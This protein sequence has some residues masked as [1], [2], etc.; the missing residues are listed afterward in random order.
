MECNLKV[1]HY[2]SSSEIGG[3]LD[4][5]DI[6]MSTF[7]DCVGDLN[8]GRKIERECC[9]TVQDNHRDHRGPRS[10]TTTFYNWSCVVSHDQTHGHHIIF[11]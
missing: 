11:I 6:G 3:E 10:F 7:Q 8:L 4:N 1:I 5:T 9:S 2:E